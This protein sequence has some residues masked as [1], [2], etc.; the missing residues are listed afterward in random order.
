MIKKEYNGSSGKSTLTYVKPAKFKN[1]LTIGELSDYLGVG[2]IW[3]RK[4]ERQDRIPKPSRLKI[5]DS[6]SIRLYSPSQVEEIRSILATHR[7]GRPR[8]V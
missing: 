2:T 6:Y 3:L 5:T 4:L 8:K 7:V 1:Y